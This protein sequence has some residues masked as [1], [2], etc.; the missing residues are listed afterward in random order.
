MTAQLTKEVRVRKV[1]GATVLDI[2]VLFSKEFVRLVLTTFIIAVPIGYSYMNL[3]L[4]EFA[5]RINI[6]MGS[7]AIQ[8]T[9][10]NPVQSLKSE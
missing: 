8:A 10:S 1:M 4:Q 9:L 7:K 5:Y 6:T 2:T 3:W